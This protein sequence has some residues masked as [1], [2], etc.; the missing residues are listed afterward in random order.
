MTTIQQRIASLR[1]KEVHRKRWRYTK[2]TA[3]EWIEHIR[4]ARDRRHIERVPDAIRERVR[5]AFIR[6]PLTTAYNRMGRA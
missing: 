5:A 4:W 2:E 3:E 6:N 1:A